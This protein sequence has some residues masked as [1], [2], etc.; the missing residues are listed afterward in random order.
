MLNNNNNNNNTTTTTITQNYDFRRKTLH[1]QIWASCH[2]TIF[3]ISFILNVTLL[4]SLRKKGRLPA[5]IHKVFATFSL[6]GLCMSLS[7]I[8]M[9]TDMLIQKCSIFYDY[10]LS[11]QK[12]SGQT[13]NGCVTFFYAC[14]TILTLERVTTIYMPYDVTR[15]HRWLTIIWMVS[16]LF[17]LIVSALMDYIKFLFICCLIVPMVVL[18]ISN[19]LLYHQVKKHINRISRTRPPPQSSFTTI[20]NN[21]VKFEQEKVLDDSLLRAQ[22]KCLWM[23]IGY[24]IFWLPSLALSLKHL[25]KR[26]AREK[27]FLAHSA[28]L[29]SSLGT[30]FVP[31]SLVISNKLLKERLQ[32][33]YLKLF[34]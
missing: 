6:I 11:V 18:V 7:G 15:S 16:L 12:L 5:I 25:F 27:P 3:I 22:M 30:I 10:N 28:F 20:D 2:L 33:M 8:T 31:C 29:V 34:E 21:N 1:I 9:A 24:C 4:T 17:C 13:I 14:F 26:N 19:C 23:V 32:K